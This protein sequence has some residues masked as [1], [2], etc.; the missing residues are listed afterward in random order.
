MQGRTITLRKTAKTDSDLA[1]LQLWRHLLSDAARLRPI[2]YC[3]NGR[4]RGA[5]TQ[6]EREPVAR[7][8]WSANA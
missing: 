6:Y 1:C 7:G 2:E 8:I 5:A 3:L 4:R